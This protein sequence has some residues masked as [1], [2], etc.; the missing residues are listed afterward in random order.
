MKV[1][2]SMYGVEFSFEFQLFKE[3]VKGGL[4]LTT[5]L[6]KKLKERSEQKQIEELFECRQFL[7]GT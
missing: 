5:G 2:G 7:H 1:S 4:A 3:L 6:Y